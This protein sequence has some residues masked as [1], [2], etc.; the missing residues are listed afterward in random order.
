MAYL[1]TVTT[2]TIRDKFARL[3]QMATVLNLERVTP[4]TPSSPA[5]TPPH[6]TP[7]RVRVRV[8]GEGGDSVV[9]CRSRRSWTTGGPTRGP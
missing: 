8:G 5:P 9:C 2:W 7:L 6:P 3:T 1:T 4:P